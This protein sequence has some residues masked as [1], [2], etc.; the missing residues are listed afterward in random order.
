MTWKC[1]DP[2]SDPEVEEVKESLEKPCRRV[3]AAI[4]EIGGKIFLFSG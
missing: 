3:G 4:A 1:L 2:G